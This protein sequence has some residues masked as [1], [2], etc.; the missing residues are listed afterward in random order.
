MPDA[1]GGELRT[2][3]AVAEDAPAILAMITRVFAEYGLTCEPEGFDRDL[4]DPGAYCR[5]HGGEF[6]V[7]E[8][9][10]AIVATVGVTVEGEVGEL[11]RLYVDRAARGHRLGRRLTQHGIEFARE[12]GCTHFVAWSDTLFEHAHALYRSMGFEQFDKR[13]LEDINN[14]W[15]Y[16][17]SMPLA[18]D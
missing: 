3:L 13:P 6:W 10:G 5:G 14:S 15:E 11:K 7:V 12:A 4:A 1:N 9:R 16:G 18:S 2:R 17:F 8:A